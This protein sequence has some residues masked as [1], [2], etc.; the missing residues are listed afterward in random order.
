MLREPLKAGSYE[1]G[2]IYRSRRHFDGD[3]DNKDGGHAYR[4]MMS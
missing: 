1:E 2:Y 3:Q 4:G